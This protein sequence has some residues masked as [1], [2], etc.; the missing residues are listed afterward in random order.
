MLLMCFS[1]ALSETTRRLAIAALDRPSAIR[2]STSRSLA[3]KLSSAFARPPAPMSSAM[4]SGSR[5]VPPAATLAQRVHELG[6]VADP[7]LQ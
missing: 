3:V 5:A 7:V 1:I 2:E 4:T 6:D